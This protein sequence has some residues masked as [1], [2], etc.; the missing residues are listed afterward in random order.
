LHGVDVD[1]RPIGAEQ[2]SVVLLLD[3]VGC[4]GDIV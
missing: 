4:H 1:P 3:H 2:V